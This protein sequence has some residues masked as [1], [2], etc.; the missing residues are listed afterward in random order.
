MSD[1]HI[2]AVGAHCGDMEISAGM[3]IAKMAREGKR[4]AFLHLTPGEKGHKTL[5]P[6]TY[7][8]Q[9][10]REAVKAADALGGEALFLNYKDG[11]LPADETVKF[12][13]A[14]TIR[15]VKPKVVLA[16]WTG[17]MHKDH[18]AAGAVMPDALFYAAIPGFQRA[19]PAH[20]GVTMYYTENWEDPLE[21]HPDLAVSV[22][23]QDI[24]Q[25]ESACREYALFR[26][27]VS[28][29]PYVDYYK[30]LAR[31]RGCER[32]TST[33]YAQCFGLTD[34]ARRRRADAI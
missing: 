9:K 11:E 15:E 30:A 8:V 22:D 24:E 5:D 29:F 10:R 28:A 2:L 20:G 1:F 13:I 27:E 23:P 16:H 18:T 25:W 12:Q 4:T 17:S 31:V 21:F 7:A 19:L 6:E 32:M 26:G 33:G 14:D 34:F 3:V